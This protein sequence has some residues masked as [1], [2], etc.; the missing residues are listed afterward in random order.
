MIK[1]NLSKRNLGH[2][3]VENISQE[4]DSNLEEVCLHNLKQIMIDATLEWK[5]MNQPN[6]RKPIQKFLQYLLNH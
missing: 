1:R 4:I 2:K 5:I 6:R 3:L